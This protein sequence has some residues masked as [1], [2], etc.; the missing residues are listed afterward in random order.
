MSDKSPINRYHPLNPTFQYSNLPLFQDLNE[1]TD[2][3][4]TLGI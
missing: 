1:R 3:K 4:D 2:K